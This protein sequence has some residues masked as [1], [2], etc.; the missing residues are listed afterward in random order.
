MTQKELLRMV[1]EL[2]HNQIVAL[3]NFYKNLIKYELIEGWGSQ[4]I[5]QDLNNALKT[6]YCLSHQ[7]MREEEEK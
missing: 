2:Q 1:I 5:A 6:A 3:C 7:L 4:K